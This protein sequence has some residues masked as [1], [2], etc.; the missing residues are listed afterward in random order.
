MRRAG[1]AAALVDHYDDRDWGSL[2]W[3]RLSG[4]AA[5]AAPGTPAHVEAVEALVARYPQYA[6]RP[7]EGPAIVIDVI[8]WQSW[9]AAG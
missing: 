3:V 8:S 6:G 2:W 1:T 5:V 4:P 7:P 9:S